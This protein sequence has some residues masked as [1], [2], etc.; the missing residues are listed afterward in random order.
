MGYN[1]A[2]KLF[3]DKSLNE[4][5][6]KRIYELDD[7]FND[8]ISRID[9]VSNELNATIS[10]T[11]DTIMEKI[12]GMDKR[13]RDGINGGIDGVNREIDALRKEMDE[14]HGDMVKYIDGVR[15]D[16]LKFVEDKTVKS[17]SKGNKE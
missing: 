3:D 13:Y 15:S 7:M 8:A 10:H 2:K 4:V 11:Y 6:R 1:D 9:G 16:M 14:L 17:P 5:V 12:D